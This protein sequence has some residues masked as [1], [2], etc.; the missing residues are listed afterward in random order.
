MAK[1]TKKTKKVTETTSDVL[2]QIGDELIE[3]SK[4]IE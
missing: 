1:Q 2:E 3:V 4:E